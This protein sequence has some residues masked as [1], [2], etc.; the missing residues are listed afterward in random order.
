MLNVKDDSLY[1]KAYDEAI[2]RHFSKAINPKPVLN[3]PKNEQ[4]QLE[5]IEEESKE[6][7]DDQY[8]AMKNSIMEGNA[9]RE[10]AEQ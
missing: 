8:A 5:Q 3:N 6:S 9:R 2:Q 10:K 4:A 7:E 1:L